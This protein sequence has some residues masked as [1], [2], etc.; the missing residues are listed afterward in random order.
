MRQ[1]ELHKA[2]SSVPLKPPPNAFTRFFKR[3]AFVL[4]FGTLNAFNL[5]RSVWFDTHALTKGEVFNI[6]VAACGLLTVFIGALQSRVLDVMIDFN[7]DTWKE[8]GRINEEISKIVDV[9]VKMTD[10]HLK[11]G[12]KAGSP[13]EASD[14]PQPKQTEAPKAKA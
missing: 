1:I 4:V 13:P 6:A 9:L 8:I 12:E 7:K 5:I 11:A 10:G 2:D 14:A 3:H